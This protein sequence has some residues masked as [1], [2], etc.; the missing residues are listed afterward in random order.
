MPSVTQPP[1]S[2]QS[3]AASAHP[4]TVPCSLA[5]FSPSAACASRATGFTVCSRNACACPAKSGAPG[6]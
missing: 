6:L 2:A 1:A 3:R 4:P 5:S